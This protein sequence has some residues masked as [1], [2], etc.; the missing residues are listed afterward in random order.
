[1]SH[2]IAIA[3]QGITTAEHAVGIIARRVAEAEAALDVATQAR[4]VAARAKANATERMGA[5]SVAIAGLRKIA[6]TRQL[7]E[8]EAAELNLAI[9]DQVD[10]QRID[11]DMANELQAADAAVATTNADLQAARRGLPEARA[12]LDMQRAV[13]AVRIAEQT[14]CRALATAATL[15]MRQGASEHPPLERFSAWVGRCQT[16]H[17]AYRFGSEPAVIDDG[18]VYE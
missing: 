14:L 4:D 3:Q 11:A 9:L 1:M 10:L 6:A 15:Q 12:A 16:L 5:K 7:T 13:A 17:R 18:E 8:S 2:L